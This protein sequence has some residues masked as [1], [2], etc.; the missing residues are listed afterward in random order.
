MNSFLAINHIKELLCS[1]N[2]HW[3]QLM[4]QQRDHWEVTGCLSSWSISFKLNTPSCYSSPVL[5]T[6][7]IIRPY[8]I[9]ECWWP[10]THVHCTVN[11]VCQIC[12][13]ARSW[14]HPSP[15]SPWCWYLCSVMFCLQLPLYVE[16]YIIICS[17]CAFTPC[18]SVM[19]KKWSEMAICSMQ[20]HWN[21]KGLIRIKQKIVAFM[22][23]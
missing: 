19:S 6:I 7:V 22:G 5:C 21:A 14:W 8:F 1:I 18:G 11:P 20:G 3:L 23:K 16:F 17:A 15:S 2:R 12:D 13:I 9:L 4:C 10:S